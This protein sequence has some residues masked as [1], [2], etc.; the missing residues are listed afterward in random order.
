M[1]RVVNAACNSI[2]QVLLLKTATELGYTKEVLYV[3][4]PFSYTDYWRDIY[5]GIKI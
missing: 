2:T 4:F 1:E 5:L 3:Y